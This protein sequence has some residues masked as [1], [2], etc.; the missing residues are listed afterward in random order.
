[1]GG[2]DHES[3]VLKMPLDQ[4]GD[5]GQACR[6][7]VRHGL[8]KQPDRR[9]REVQQCE[10]HPAALPSRQAAGETVSET[11]R[12]GGKQCGGNRLAPS[13]TGYPAH[14]SREP[15]ILGD[16]EVTLERGIMPEVDEVSLELGRSWFYR[17]ALPSERPTLD[18][19]Q[20]AQGSE[21]CG[22]AA[23]VGAEYLK[24]AAWRDGEV[25]PGEDWACTAAKGQID[26]FKHVRLSGRR[27][28]NTR[29]SVLVGEA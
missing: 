3:A 23:A 15:Q 9:R 10:R 25:Q 24:A 6:I 17:A 2:G 20:A 22:L 21:Q 29:I 27:G 7:E 26:D 4:A 5:Q 8:I 16:A 19:K 11:G 13:H 28:R 12:V 1:M 14:H 18:L